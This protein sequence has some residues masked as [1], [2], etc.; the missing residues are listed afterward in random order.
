VHRAGAQDHF[1]RTASRLPVAV[2][3]KL[4]AGGPIP[5]EQNPRRVGAGADLEVRPP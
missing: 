5:V 4:D 2:L 1:V 3:E